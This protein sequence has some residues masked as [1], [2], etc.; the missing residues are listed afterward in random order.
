MSFSC[1]C[2]KLVNMIGY[3]DART[4]PRSD[5]W[6]VPFEQPKIR[7][8]CRQVLGQLA[9]TIRNL[10]HTSA[11]TAR[12]SHPPVKRR[13]TTLRSQPTKSSV[14]TLLTLWFRPSCVEDHH[15]FVDGGRN[16]SANEQMNL[17]SAWW[18]WR[19]PSG[20]H[21]DEIAD[22]MTASRMVRKDARLRMA[23]GLSV[24]RTVGGTR[25]GE[26]PYRRR[27]AAKNKLDLHSPHVPVRLSS[28]SL[29]YLLRRHES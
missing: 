27:P 15:E 21:V 13:F 1:G 3:L 11:P 23:S 7:F 10:K 29:Q 6:R 14:Q 28:A 25:Y 4:W 24:L 22:F 20:R 26:M 5:N 2:A 16:D 19:G 8:S 9:D 12:A 17:P 18:A